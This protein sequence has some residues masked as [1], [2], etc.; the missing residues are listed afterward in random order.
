MGVLFHISFLEF[1]WRK[2][3]KPV[4]CN[5]NS[6]LSNIFIRF[7][8]RRIEDVIGRYCLQGT[9]WTLRDKDIILI[10]DLY[11]CFFYGRPRYFASD[12][13]HLKS[14]A[15]FSK[16]PKSFRT[17]KAV[18]KFQT[19]WL[20]SCFI[21][22]FLIRTEVLFIQEVDTSLSLNTDELKMV[23]RAW[24]DSGLSDFDFTRLFIVTSRLKS[25]M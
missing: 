13:L 24:K 7:G 11:I 2:E 21:H 12:L 16:V 6:F 4:R 15:R 9:T 14:G 3:T 17:L 22:I 18:A 10:K 8:L 1:H 20:Q 23:F 5:W 25:S 19:F